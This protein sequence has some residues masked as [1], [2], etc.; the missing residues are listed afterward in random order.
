MSDPFHIVC[1]H[2]Q[3]VNPVPA[4]HLNQTPNCGQ[5]YRHLFEAPS[6]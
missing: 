1:P 3:A 5:C 4:A 6:G 2:C